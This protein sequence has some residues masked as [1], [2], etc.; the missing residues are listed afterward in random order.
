MRE[1]ARSLVFTNT[2]SRQTKRRT[3]A[4]YHT[5]PELQGRTEYIH[6]LLLPLS[7]GFIPI[8]TAARLVRNI[9]PTVSRRTWFFSL[10]RKLFVWNWFCRFLLWFVEWIGFIL[11]W[12]FRI[13]N[14]SMF[15]MYNNRGERDRS[16][17]CHEAILI[18]QS[19]GKRTK[20]N[21]VN[22]IVCDR[23]F[24][25]EIGRRWASSERT[26]KKEKRRYVYFLNKILTRKFSKVIK[27]PD[28]TFCNLRIYSSLYIYYEYISNQEYRIDICFIKLTT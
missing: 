7:Y 15:V 12:I 24:S 14:R 28:D 20:F 9:P 19:N 22:R 17:E 5:D 11:N 3:N 16:K 2:F 6:T 10:L 26:D 13:G 8:S 23:K 27:F 25:I 1:L 4:R 18:V 21:E